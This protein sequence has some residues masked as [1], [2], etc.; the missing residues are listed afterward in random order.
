M[1]FSASRLAIC[2]NG[3]VISVQNILHKIE[4]GLLVD[5]L[6]W[7]LFTEHIIVSELLNRR[8]CC[9]YFLKSNLV[10]TFV[11]HHN[12]FTVWVNLEVPLWSS[13]W[14]IGLHLTMTL[15]DS[16]I[17]KIIT[18][19]F[20][21]IIE[22]IPLIY[23]FCYLGASLLKSYFALFLSDREQSIIARRTLFR[24]EKQK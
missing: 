6:L 21:I 24:S 8:V 2:E 20:D 10:C 23:I 12:I 11:N 22:M 7:R 17:S 14:F 19:L 1:G 13:F 15:T 4:R 5:L 18:Q 16:V 9:C 3:T